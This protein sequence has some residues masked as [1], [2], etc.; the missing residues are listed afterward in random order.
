MPGFKTWPC[1]SLG[2]ATVSWLSL[3]LD[4]HTPDLKNRMIN[5]YSSE[6]L[7]GSCMRRPLCSWFIS[8]APG[9]GCLLGMPCL[10]VS[11]EPW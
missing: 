3:T 10:F 8:S 9:M 1:S 4:I 5:V 2:L 11:L 7:G 6:L